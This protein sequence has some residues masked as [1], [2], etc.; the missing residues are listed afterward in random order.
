MKRRE[1][2]QAAVAGAA[3]AGAA[4]AAGAAA[5][6]APAP[7]A[8]AGAVAPGKHDVV[9]LSFDPKKLA[10]LSEKLLVSH[11]D[12]NYAGAVK[13]LNKVEEELARVNKDTPGFLVAG[14]RERELTF[15]NSLI[16]HELYFGNLGGDGK[17]AGA[18]AAA[19][20]EAF[21][22][23]ARFEELFR[24]TGASLGGGSGWAV[25]SLNFRTG[26]LNVYGSG[27]HT[28]ALASGQPLLVMDMYEH[29]YAM[30]YG[31]AAA[32]YIDAFFQNARWD[33]VDRRY[34]R[35]RK[36]AATLLA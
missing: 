25:L 10:G 11:H 26:H 36:A 13:N 7:A 22:S 30:D 9:P 16:L 33:E 1:L 6:P 12:N 28:Q 20:G 5:P 18:V 2:L 3:M 34:Q 19:L 17:A 8:P 21:G 35:A 32:K 24:A 23:L 29:A 15:T 31:A 27:N 14:L 4:A